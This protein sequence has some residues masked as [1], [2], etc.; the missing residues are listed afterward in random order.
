MIKKTKLCEY[1]SEIII[2][3]N[4][5]IIVNEYLEYKQR[6]K[7]TIDRKSYTEICND[8]LLTYSISNVT[9]RRNSN[10]ICTKEEIVV[11]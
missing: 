4:S 2:N 6:M 10:T 1:Y 8:K 5:I 9:Y 11:I 7:K 3:T